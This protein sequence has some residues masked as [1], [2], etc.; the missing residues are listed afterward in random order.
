MIQNMEL[1]EKERFI[2]LWQE[3]LVCLI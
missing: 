1:S 2:E 3:K